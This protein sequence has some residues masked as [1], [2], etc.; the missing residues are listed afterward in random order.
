MRILAVKLQK[1]LHNNQAKNETRGHRSAAGTGLMWRWSVMCTQ[2]MGGTPQ[3]AKYVES[4]PNTTSAWAGWSRF[5]IPVDRYGG[6][7]SLLVCTSS[8]L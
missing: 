8:T 4:R 7:H 6:V 1:Q 5:D 3:E 2:C